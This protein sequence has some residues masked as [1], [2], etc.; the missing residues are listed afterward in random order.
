ML[1]EANSYLKKN[2]KMQVLNEEPQVY[3]AREQR[4]LSDMICTHVNEE[5]SSSFDSVTGH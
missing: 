1:C 2:S 3:T 5:I 4:M